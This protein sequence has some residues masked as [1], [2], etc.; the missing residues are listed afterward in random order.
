MI[1]PENITRAQAKQLIRLIDEWT[2]AEVMSRM[3]SFE[4]KVWMQAAQTKIEKEDEIR[5]MV[6]GTSDISVLA[7]RW[8]IHTTPKI[9]KRKK[10]KQHTI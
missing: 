9:K 3:G 5:K 10:K 1:T 4:S 6:L 7:V 8:K 2:R